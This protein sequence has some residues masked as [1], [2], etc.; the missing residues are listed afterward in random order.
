MEYLTE[1]SIGDMLKVIEAIGG[2]L[3][4]KPEDNDS[5]FI[6]I[7]KKT[8][9][10]VKSEY[11]G[12]ITSRANKLCM[13]FPVLCSNTV[14]PSTASMITKAIERKCTL[15]LQQ[16]FAA[17]MLIV[18]KNEGG[19]QHAINNV[20]T[21]IDFDTLSVD[22]LIN[23]TST[24]SPSAAKIFKTNE[25]TYISE[26]TELSKKMVNGKTYE[27]SISESPISL[28]NVT[29]KSNIKVD[30][31]MIPVQEKSDADRDK[32]VEEILSKLDDLSH[33]TKNGNISKD[34]FHTGSN[35]S[36]IIDEE[37][38][39]ENLTRELVNKYANHELKIDD[40]ISINKDIRDRT[41]LSMDID[42]FV[43][44]TA[45]DNR[46]REKFKYELTKAIDDIEFNRSKMRMEIEKNQRERERAA[47]DREAHAA[48][49]KAYD[50]QALQFKQ[51][52]FKK[53]LMDTDVKK[54]NELV[55]SMLMV[56]YAID[57]GGDKVQD[58]AIVGVKARLI[59]LDSFQILD[60]MASKN[61]DKS[62]LV[63]FIKA[64]TGEIK[65][66]KDFILAI[67]KAKIDALNR[68][69]R[70]SSNPIWRVLE[71]RAAINNLRKALGQKNDA[72]PITTLVITQEEVDYLKKTANM[73]LDDV[74]TANYIINAYNLMGLCIV[75]ETAE[76]AKF[77][78]DGEF[79]Q[80][81]AYAF[82]SLQ[83]ETGDNGMYKKV[84]NLMTKRM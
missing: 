77:L 42:K 83:K 68:S 6:T 46:E 66:M 78:F 44:D 2:V 23:I 63:K 12:S 55:P 58:T 82:T 7:L 38:I 3:K 33:S 61:K 70:G 40:I 26:I 57:L 28:Y 73:H 22:D 34:Y 65:F 19:I 51:D 11:T 52:L 81:D 21:G 49:M 18:G 1:T 50:R 62:G 76:V 24:I 37:K 4:T 56:N 59:S 60:K 53:Q 10:G 8:G 30:P 27:S 84:I 80:F 5:K 9:K 13:T 32:I 47:R 17:D 41:N 35:I 36:K 71:R 15:M 48:Q 79:N 20:Y 31:D 64:T 25:S 72:S 16:I 45:K 14:T 29:E 43:R 74:N 39:K 75:D 67:D 54:A 69:K